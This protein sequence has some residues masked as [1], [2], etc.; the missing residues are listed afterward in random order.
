MSCF[1]LY[2]CSPASDSNSSL[3]DLTKS[4]LNWFSAGFEGAFSTPVALDPASRFL[5]V[6]VAMISRQSNRV[7]T[8]ALCILTVPRW[9]HH[10]HSV[11]P[12]RDPDSARAGT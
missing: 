5:L 1:Q 12:P 6:L 9:R 7:L 3:L 11:H 4:S 10:F 2:F 8:D